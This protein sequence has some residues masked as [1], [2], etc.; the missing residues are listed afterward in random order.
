MSSKLEPAIKWMSNIKEFCF[1]LRPHVLLA[2]CGHHVVWCHCHVYAFM[3]NTASHFYH[4]KSDSQ[5]SMSVGLCLAAQTD[6]LIMY[7]NLWP[8]LLSS[9][10]NQNVFYLFKMSL[11]SERC[12]ANM[13]S[14]VLYSSAKKPWG[15]WSAFS[16]HVE[17]CDDPLG[18]CHKRS[19]FWTLVT[20]GSWHEGEWLIYI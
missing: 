2:E 16:G 5:V 15:S 8:L 7:Y 12:H 13:V 11:V 10:N 18:A 1:S 9:H 20:N 6:L 17:L 14:C 19:A 3:I 4:G